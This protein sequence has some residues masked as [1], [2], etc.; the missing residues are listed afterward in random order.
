MKYIRKFYHCPQC[1][2]F[3]TQKWPLLKGHLKARHG[4]TI[5]PGKKESDFACFEITESEY[6]NFPSCRPVPGSEESCSGSSQGIVFQLADAFIEQDWE[7]VKK[8][9]R[10]LRNIF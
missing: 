5:N 10:V 9:Y 6:N 7:K 3:S 1:D 4:I 8:V 2:T